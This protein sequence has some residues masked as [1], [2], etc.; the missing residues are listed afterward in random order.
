MKGKNLLGKLSLIS[1]LAIS[2]QSCKKEN[3]IDNN[4][5]I[6]RPYVLYVAD[7][8]GTL[9]KSNDGNNYKTILAGDGT[10]IRAISTSKEKL[11]FVKS[12]RLFVSSD[13][14]TSFNPLLQNRVSVPTNIVGS[15][16]LLDI[17]SLNRVYLTNTLSIRG[18][19]S[20]SPENGK[21]FN[22][23]TSWAPGM[24][25]AYVIETF[26]YLDN[27]NLCGYSPTGSV[28]GTTSLFIKKHKDSV[29]LPQITDLPGSV[30][31]QL[32]NKGNTI[33]ATDFDGIKGSY[34]SDDMG[35]TFK[36]FTGLPSAKKLYCTHSS[37]N[38]ILIGTEKN[39]VYLTSGT[40]FSPSNSGIDA[41]TSVY[42]IAAKENYYKNGVTKKF[43]YLATSTGI[44]KSEDMAKSWIKVNKD[45]D[46][47]TIN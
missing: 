16:F 27:Q 23:D 14:G 39:G 46:F 33:I 47:R 34:Y 37:S 13:T 36:A 11:L 4:N 10:P 18:K 1:L 19:V 21:Y 20:L 25:S 17:P 30:K 22:P 9:L 43:F 7:A 31:Y 41:Q 44:Y 32:A 24:D 35:K 15:T 42:G 5:V 12:D 45:G 3:G 2:S 40:S 29:W 6:Q 8:S 28:N 38:I 26:T